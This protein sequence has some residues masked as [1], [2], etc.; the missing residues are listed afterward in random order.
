MCS[1]VKFILAAAGR[2]ATTLE[3]TMQRVAPS[4]NLITRPS[5]AVK[6]RLQMLVKLAQ[7]LTVLPHHIWLW[8]TLSG[9]KQ[10][11]NPRM[12]DDLTGRVV[13]VDFNS[14]NGKGGWVRGGKNST[15]SLLYG[16]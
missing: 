13:W 3:S 8:R 16:E 14:M 11:E 10:G 1:E 6:Y 7:N 5:Q 15:L 12:T 4:D 9:P 2:S